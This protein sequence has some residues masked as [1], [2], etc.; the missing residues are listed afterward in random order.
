MHPS[1]PWGLSFK[2]EFFADILTNRPNVDF[3]EV[4]A[5]N[6]MAPGGPALAQLSRLANQHRLSIHGVGLSIG[7][8]QRPCSL[9]LARLK[10]LLERFEPFLFSEHLAWSGHGG[11]YF[12]DLLPIAYTH[13]NLQRVCAHVDEIQTTLG[14]SML[15]ENPSTYVSFSNSELTETEFLN[16]LAQRTGCKFLLDV[17]N[18]VVSCTNNGACPQA[19]LNSLTLGH[20]AQYHLA[21]HSVQHD[22]LGAPLLIDDHGSAPSAEVLRL[23]RATLTKTGPLPTLLEWDN[24]LP[25]WQTLLQTLESLR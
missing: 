21:G 9:H 22:S 25:T 18:V 6:Y 8:A 7:G 11:Q 1:T 13:D 24:E 14:R 23:Y 15:I 19:W 3:F 12:N 5:E 16:A 2:P 20:V 10:T 17:N 4:H